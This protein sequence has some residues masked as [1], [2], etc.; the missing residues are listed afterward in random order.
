M[1]KHLQLAATTWPEHFYLISASVNQTH[2]AHDGAVT[3]GFAPSRDSMGSKAYNLLRM[4]QAGLPVPPALV[5]GTHFAHQPK[6]VTQPLFQ[7]GIPALEAASGQVFGDTRKPLI[8]SVRSGAPISMPGMMETLLNIGLCDATLPGLLRQ[9]GNPR[10]VW[11]A[12]RRLV[13][14]YAEVVAGLPAALFETALQDATQGRDERTLDF[15]E[16]RDLTRR[17]L[18]LYAEHAVQPFPQD[19]HAQLSQ[20][21]QAVFASWDS[22]K[23]REYRKL[24]QIDEAIGTA[25]TIQRMVFGN[26][27]GRSGAGVGFTRNPSN[28]EPALWIDFLANAQGEDV[29][30]GRRNAHGHEAMAD[31]APDAWHELTC[32]TRTL[33]QL[34]GDMQDFEFTVEDS[35]L[36][37]LQARSGKRTLLAA[38][39]IALDLH[40]EGLIDRNTALQRTETLLAEDLCT[41]HLANDS[42]APAQPVAQAASACSGV[43][44]GEIALDA[45]RAAKRAAKGHSV[46]LVRNDAETRD[47]AALEPSTGLLTRNGARTSHAAVVA[48]QLGKVCL[49]G[50]ESLRIDSAARSVQLGELLL[51]EG[52]TL[53]LDGNE[54][55]VYHGRIATVREP[56]QQVIGRLES[57]RS[58][59]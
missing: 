32:A 42:G 55:R 54:G 53:T 56:D 49:V 48:R 38:A 59:E 27:G 14:S 29:V 20:A 43:S 9:T 5:L 39:R 28:G 30:S 18:A 23:A 8:V 37:L 2:A 6:Q 34:F 57:L 58:A 16:L 7:A 35:L 40:D 36:Y 12:Y 4:A 11:D 21:V 22:D 3:A 10:L 13:A 52:D 41:V 46:I 26:A 47:I 25:V 44:S 50:C 51:Q 31:L 15:T 1:S 17:Y 24:N 33:E 45:E 19:V